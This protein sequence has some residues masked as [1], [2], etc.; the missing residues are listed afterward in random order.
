MSNDDGPGDLAADHP[1]GLPSVAAPEEEEGDV[2]AVL[3]PPTPRRPSH[4]TALIRESRRSLAC[5]DPTLLEYLEEEDEEQK[6]EDEEQQI[7]TPQSSA[8]FQI[9]SPTTAVVG[10]G[11]MS[12]R[13]QSVRHRISMMAVPEPH[14][15]EV[16][17]DNYSYSV[18]VRADA[19]TVKTIFNQSV[20]YGAYELIRRIHQYRIYRKK[21]NPTP[22]RNS[23]WRPT[24]GTQVFNPYD[25]KVILKN[26][27]LVFSPGKSYLVL[28]PPAGGKTSLLKAIAGLLPQPNKLRDPKTKQGNIYYNGIGSDDERLVFPNLVSFVGQLDI[29]APF[30]T[31]AETFNFAHDSRVKPGADTERSNITLEGL[32]LAGC[33]DTFV[34]NSDVRYVLARL[35]S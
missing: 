31:V 4:L 27:D 9:S 25:Q 17:F 29:H 22:H 34:G 10:V 16:R 3:P 6:E 18:P 5:F 15:V 11:D 35:Q 14:L 21:K 24:K 1:N 19:P 2:L 33:A 30:L 26:I 28:G 32:G 13:M 12:D 20:C 7:K 23:I 8:A